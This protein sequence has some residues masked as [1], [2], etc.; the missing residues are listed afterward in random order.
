LFSSFIIFCQE[1]NRQERKREREIE[2]QEQGF[3]DGNWDGRESEDEEG[4]NDAL[5][6]REKKDERAEVVRNGNQVGEIMISMQKGRGIQ[7]G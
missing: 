5:Q 4:R 7:V 6:G 1:N 2:R 3:G